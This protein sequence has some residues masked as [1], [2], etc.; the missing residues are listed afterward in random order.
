MKRTLPILCALLALAPALAAQDWDASLP[1]SLDRMA[2]NYYQPIVQ[3]VFGTFTYA[4]SSLPSPF[5][6]W[7]EEGLAGAITRTSR[8]KLLNRAAAAAMDP[9][10]A[11]EYGDFFAQAEG[12]A[13]L[14]GNYFDEGRDV[15]VRLELTGVSDRTLIGVA[16][17]KVPKSAVPA[18]IAIDPSKAIVKAAN[19]LGTLLPSKSPGGLTVSV[20]TERGAGAVYRQGEEMNILVTANKDVYAK[21]YSINAAGE[22]SLIWPNQYGGSGRLAAG[23]VTR[24]PSDEEKQTFR[25]IMVPPFGTEFIKV[26]ASTVPFAQN[27]EGFASLGKD[28]KAVITRGIAIK[29]NAQA[30][31]ERAEALASYVIMDKK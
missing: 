27:E 6:R 30:S 15:R 24:I 26:V 20:S 9:A 28:L 25:F 31:P 22:V 19:D 12:G 17:F 11:K 10:F 1:A 16:E 2:E 8:L 14:H 4:Y 13:L 5:S 7:L 23:A 18:D 3:T 21:V 29:A